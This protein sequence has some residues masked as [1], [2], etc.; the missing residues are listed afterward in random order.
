MDD[1]E[2]YDYVPANTLEDGDKVSLKNEEG[3][4]DY[5]EDVRV[6]KDDPAVMVKGY[7][8]VTGDNSTYILDWDA[9]VG[10]WMV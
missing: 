1:I 9:E 3:G 8:H 4:I 10:L 5:L 2:V 7:S 6:I